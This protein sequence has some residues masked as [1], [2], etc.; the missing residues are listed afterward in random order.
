MLHLAREQLLADFL[1]AVAVVGGQDRVGVH[2]Q[3]PL[4]RRARGEHG[5]APVG[6]DG[7]ADRDE[8]IPGLG[9]LQAQL[10]EDRLVVEQARVGDGAHVQGVEAVL[11]GIAHQDVQV[12]VVDEGLVRQ[13]QQQ[14]LVD[15][16]LPGGLVDGV[17]VPVL[18]GL[19]E[20]LEGD[21]V[22]V[23]RGDAGLDDLVDLGG[24]DLADGQVV[25]RIGL[26]EGRGNVLEV[27]HRGRVGPGQHIDAR[28]LGRGRSVVAGGRVRA[29]RAGCTVLRRGRR[30]ARHPARAR[31]QRRDHEQG[32]E[33]AKQLA[34]FHDV[35]SSF[36]K[37]SIS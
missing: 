30:A 32:Q 13:V 26:V 9:D 37:V 12:V 33:Q 4:V 27:L 15:V 2:V 31:G 11:V 7:L 10:G 17:G 14:A 21:D 25:V 23:R 35:S 16:L 19:G 20:G 6:L 8:L 1:R 29:V 5:V 18:L 36:G 34:Q 28:A 24:G 22:H 3:R